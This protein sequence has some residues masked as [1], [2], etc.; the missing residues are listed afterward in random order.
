MQHA[1]LW[2][3]EPHVVATAFSKQGHSVSN[4]PPQQNCLKASSRAKEQEN[5]GKVDEL[6]RSRLERFLQTAIINN[7][8]QAKCAE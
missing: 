3:F 8:K 6:N 5:G 2:L 7:I 4:P 1:H